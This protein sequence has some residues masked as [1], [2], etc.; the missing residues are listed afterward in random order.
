MTSKLAVAAFESA[1]Q[2]CGDEAGCTLHSDRG[3]RTADRN[4]EAGSYGVH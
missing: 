3:P 1:I 2:I 4:S